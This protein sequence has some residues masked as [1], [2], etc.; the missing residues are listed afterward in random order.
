[1][2]KK[3]TNITDKEILALIKSKQKTSKE[4]A[5]VLGVDITSV[6][7]R[8]KKLYEKGLVIRQQKNKEAGGYT[9]FYKV[10]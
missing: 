2:R 9:Y 8:M 10:K 6:Q 5:E 3:H 4:M 1:M 7:R